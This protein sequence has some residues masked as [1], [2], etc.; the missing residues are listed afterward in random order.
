V[1][2]QRVVLRVCWGRESQPNKLFGLQLEFVAEVRCAVGKGGAR[3]NKVKGQRQ[4]VS[5]GGRPWPISHPL[6]FERLQPSASMALASR[7]D[8]ADIRPL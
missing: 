2:S 7:S 6:S 8:V 3:P 5:S 1:V 4:K